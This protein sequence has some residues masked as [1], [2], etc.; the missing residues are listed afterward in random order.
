MIE[1]VMLCPQCQGSGTVTVMDTKKF[2]KTGIVEWMYYPCPMCEGKR[3]VAVDTK[4]LV[5]I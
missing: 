1:Q 4:T 5:Q 3:F 2:D